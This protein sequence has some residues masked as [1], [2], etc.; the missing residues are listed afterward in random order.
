MPAHQV[1]VSPNRE[2]VTPKD[3]LF[4]LKA[5]KKA[6]KAR[7]DSSS[8]SSQA[9]AVSPLGLRRVQAQRPVNPFR[10][11]CTGE[12]RRCLQPD[13]SQ[14]DATVDNTLFEILRSGLGD[15]QT[16]PELNSQSLVTSFSQALQRDKSGKLVKFCQ[17][18]QPTQHTEEINVSIDW[19]IQSHVRVL[20]RSPF[21]WSAH[22]K[23]V[24]ESSAL[25]ASVRCLSDQD[26]PDSSATARL[27]RLCFFW[28]HP[29]LPWLHLYPRRSRSV[30]HSSP[31]TAGGGSSA[32]S[33]NSSR[34]FS[35]DSALQQTLHADWCESLRSLFQLVRS[36][37]CAFFYVCCAS[38]TCLFR[39]AGLAGLSETHAILSPTTHGLRHLL[40]QD[41]VEFSMPLRGGDT[42]EPS[43]V[44]GERSQCVPSSEVTSGGEGDVG[45]ID[46]EDEDATQ[47][48]ESIGIETKSMPGISSARRKV[49]QRSNEEGGGEG[50]GRT[51][52]SSTVLVQ[53]ASVNAL[54]NF[55]LNSRACIA[56]TGSLA[57]V[58][59]TLLAPVAFQ[60]GTLQPLKKRQSSVLRGGTSYHSL[61]LSGGPVM[62]HTLHSLLLLLR[63][64]LSS[65]SV[66][67]S[68]SSSSSSAGQSP[69]GSSSSSGAFN[70]VGSPCMSAVFSAHSL[71]E[72]GLSSQW[73]Q[74]AC[75][76]FSHRSPSTNTLRSTSFQYADGKF[77]QCSSQLP[78]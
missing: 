12:P 6:L 62:T 13:V 8:R 76:S 46:D 17:P 29:W 51:P 75:S 47:W 7:L 42:G 25:T 3:V 52:A 59:P 63:D 10:V 56:S 28:Q 53:G 44:D 27:H 5:K 48:L 18:S 26:A 22:L 49:E 64:S 43:E 21:P 38:F 54:L 19:E 30:R 31:A 66:E 35:T 72:C 36:R 58:P 11:S 20:S 24:E 2:W 68:S 57:G 69:P 33:V 32:A 23:T 14:T 4:K 74:E 40:K 73:V 15:V 39:A 16:Q 60:G 34:L 65:F 61:E 9:N 70:S 55:L 78:C 41:G 1:A 71:S 45:D 67:L 50:T 37:Q 77:T